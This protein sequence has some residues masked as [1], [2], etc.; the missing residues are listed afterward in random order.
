MGVLHQAN[1]SNSCF[2]GSKIWL[3]T[4][5]Y[6]FAFFVPKFL[7]LMKTLHKKVNVTVKPDIET[8]KSNAKREL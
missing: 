8:E 6:V 7:F 5:C 4:D 2:L 3:V 1:L